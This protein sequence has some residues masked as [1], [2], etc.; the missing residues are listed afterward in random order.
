MTGFARHTGE[1]EW[2]MWTWEARSVNGKGLD[3]RVNL[4]A[5]LD[6]LERQIK[7]SAAARFAR[8]N[9]YLSL[10][11][12][13][14]DAAGAIS[15]NDSLLDALMEAFALRNGGPAMGMELATLMTSRGVV[16]LSPGTTE[17]LADDPERIAALLNSAERALEGLKA[18]RDQEGVALHQVLVGHLSEIERL[19]LE[20]VEYSTQQV[21][22]IAQLYRTRLTALDSEG[23]VPEDRIATEIAALAAK[24]DV[25]EEIDRLRAHIATGRKHLASDEAAGRHLGFLAQELNREANTL[26]SKSASLDLTNAGLALK[27]VVDQFKEQ[28]ANVE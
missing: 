16:D 20:A 22:A 21:L 18:A 12:E 4:P 24:A 26:C 6:S 10:R 28:A 17:R 8:G 2:G 14:S 19:T 7:S 11:L 5:G 25:T 23:A 13:L 15:V 9:V 27:S 1:A 3:V